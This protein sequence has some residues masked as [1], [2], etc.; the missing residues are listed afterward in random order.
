MS[1]IHVM[2]DVLQ[3]NR[4]NYLFSSHLLGINGKNSPVYNQVYKSDIVSLSLSA[5]VAF[6]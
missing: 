2:L 1:V 3:H 4:H 5:N 6:I